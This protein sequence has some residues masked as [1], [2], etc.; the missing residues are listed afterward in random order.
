MGNI[1][2]FNSKIIQ[3]FFRFILGSIF[4][5]AGIYKISNPQEF[6]TSIKNLRILSSQSINTITF[7]LPWVELFLGVLLIT[8]ILKRYIALIS[9]ILLLIF[10][11]V[12]I[13]STFNGG[14]GSC[15]C[16]PESS[17][18]NS[19]NPFIIVIRNFVFIIFGIAIIFLGRTKKS[20]LLIFLKK[21]TYEFVFVISMAFLV[22]VLL[23]S[24][25]KI[26]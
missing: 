25:A 10:I 7:L 18:L 22:S 1:K 15:G 20:K 6:F 21:H 9:T 17:I 12:T 16:F 3:L 26:N 8:G 23:I 13:S 14:I 4:I 19:Y 2:F 5:Y 11:V 24:F